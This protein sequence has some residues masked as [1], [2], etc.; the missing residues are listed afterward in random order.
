MKIRQRHLSKYRNTKFMEM[1]CLTLI[2]Y[3]LLRN[4]LVLMTFVNFCSFLV[5]TVETGYNNTGYN[6]NSLSTTY[7]CLSRQNSYLLYTFDFSFSDS[8][9]YDNSPFAMPLLH[10]RKQ[11]YLILRQLSGYCLL[12]NTVAT[13]ASL[14]A[15]TLRAKGFFCELCKAL[16]NNHSCVTTTH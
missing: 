6:D 16:F 4:Y 13:N 2:R 8:R 5:S 3:L 10:P 1:L 14:Y 12:F 7:F 9:F 11:N 15:L